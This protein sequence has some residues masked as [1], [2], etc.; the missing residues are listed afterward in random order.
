MLSQLHHPLHLKMKKRLPDGEGGWEEADAGTI[1]VWAAIRPLSSSRGETVVEVIFRDQADLFEITEALWV[2]RPLIPL[3][4]PH[5]LEK[6]RGFLSFQ[7]LLLQ[8]KE[9]PD[10]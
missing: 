8:P 2:K 10:A 7:A 9:N 3:S 4:Q 5:P 6:Q 1:L